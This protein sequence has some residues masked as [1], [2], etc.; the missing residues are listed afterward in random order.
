MTTLH[1]LG[2]GRGGVVGP[3]WQTRAA[4][5]VPVDA[6]LL[7]AGVPAD[8]ATTCTCVDQAFADVADGLR[9]QA[10][11]ASGAL[12]DMLAANAQIAADAALRAR[13]RARITAGDP[14]V[15]AVDGAVSVFAARFEQ[16]GGRVA[17]RVADLRAVRDRVVAAVFGLSVP[18]PGLERPSVVVAGDLAP[19]DAAALDLEH[20]LA[21]V[22]ER[23]GP[24]SHT[25][26]V[27][28][29]LGIPCL[30]QVAGATDLADG[31]VVAVDAAAGTLTVDPDDAVR[32]RLDARTQADQALAADASPGATA[33][34]R[35]VPLLVNV[36]SVVDAERA[37]AADMEGVGLF[38]T[39]VLY[40]NRTTAP[41][42]AEQ[43]AVYTR[44]LRTLAGRT[45]VVRT[46]DVGTDKPLPFTAPDAAENPALGVR[47]YRLVRTHPELF[48]TQ[49]AALA[50]AARATGTAPWV[51]APMVTTADE[52][53]DVATAVRAAGLPTAGVMV[54][55]PAAALR[56][57]QILAEV[58]FC[59]VG[60][61]D[62]A[63][64]TMA[65]SRELGAL[66][67]LLSPWQPAVL[68]LVATTAQAGVRTGKPVGVCGES[69]A[70][71]VMALV[72][73]GLGVTSLSMAPSAVPV[74]RYALRRHPLARCRDLAEAALAARSAPEAR[75]AA[76][77]LVDPTVRAA[78]GW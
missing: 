32:A 2:V 52:A 15:A 9:A 14:P 8:T 4:V 48:G 59:S 57:E 23:G 71:P 30:V 49:L 56:A 19:A 11:Q 76:L 40:L 6:P 37:A 43:T 1:G 18:V 46:L 64:Y 53:R 69:A 22:T 68:D 41:T 72:L 28:G 77:A 7:V 36:G 3:V 62:L 31:V 26:V 44:L 5:Q 38:R 10:E 24:T 74:V 47:G 42:L 67:D 66:A 50:A 60:T 13:V 12:A 34:G 39:E 16:A 55:V 58:D 45:V 54:E 20:V 35:P 27:A 65:T 70:D 17:E 75:A 51:M 21:L 61:N 78:L 29:Q 73:V 25:A 63:Q 33:D